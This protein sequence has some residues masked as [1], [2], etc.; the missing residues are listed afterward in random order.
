M[1]WIIP[2]SGTAP[3]KVYVNPTIFMTGTDSLAFFRLDVSFGFKNGAAASGSVN[4]R[5]Y[6]YRTD[7]QLIVDLAGIIDK[8]VEVCHVSLLIDGSGVALPGDTF[9]LTIPQNSIDVGVNPLNAVPEPATL[10]LMGLG[11]P[12]WWVLSRSPTRRRD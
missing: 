1:D 11:L 8:R 2:A 10:V 6:D 3:N 7:G 12:A 4:G 5:D 9:A